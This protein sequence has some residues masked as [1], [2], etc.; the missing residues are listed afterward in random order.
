MPHGKDI[1]SAL[2]DLGAVH[3]VYTR[4]GDI[5]VPVPKLLHMARYF[6]EVVVNLNGFPWKTAPRHSTLPD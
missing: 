3:F 5:T 1:L 4:R 2:A 6:Q